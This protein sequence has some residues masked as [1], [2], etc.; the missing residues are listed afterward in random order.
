MSLVHLSCSTTCLAR[1]SYKIKEVRVHDCVLSRLEGSGIFLFGQ[2]GMIETS[3]V[4]SCDSGVMTGDNNKIWNLVV[5]LHVFDSLEVT[6]GTAVS[7]IVILQPRSSGTVRVTYNCG[8]RG[9]QDGSNSVD[10]HA[11]GNNIPLIGPGV[12]N[13]SKTPIARPAVVVCP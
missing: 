5:A 3:I 13:R 2:E 6:T 10:G 8:A 1:D 4:R 12:P 11:L 9:C 7:R